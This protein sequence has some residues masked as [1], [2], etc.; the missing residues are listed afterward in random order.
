M[1]EAASGM[2]MPGYEPTEEAAALGYIQDQSF[3]SHLKYTPDC[4]FKLSEAVQAS[5]SAPTFFPG[6]A[7]GSAGC[8]HAESLLAD[9]HMHESTWL[10]I[11]T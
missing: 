8:R 3:Q 10:S 5:C 7:A 1:A 2:V 11:I 4:I 6:N 9:K